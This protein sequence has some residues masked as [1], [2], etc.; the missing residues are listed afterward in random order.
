MRRGLR[1]R[2]PQD[3]RIA[4]LREIEDPQGLHADA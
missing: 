1:S 4:Q 3:L 2:D